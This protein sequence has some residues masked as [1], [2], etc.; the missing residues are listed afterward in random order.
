MHIFPFKIWEKV[1]DIRPIKAS[2]SSFIAINEDSRVSHPEDSRLAALTPQERDRIERLVERKVNYAIAN[3]IN[4]QPFFSIPITRI[5]YVYTY[6]IDTAAT[7]GTYM[8]INPLFF[9]KL[10]VRSVEFVVL[11][12]LLHCMLEHFLRMDNR[13]P[14]QWNIATDHEINLI[15]AEELKFGNPQKDPNLSSVI[16]VIYDEKYENMA[17]EEI[18]NIITSGPR[19]EEPTGPEGGTGP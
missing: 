16:I 3:I 13:D 18:Y 6:R 4:T 7:D 17:A 9:E 5:K 1:L 15:V 12:E 8:L 10:N 19:P 14:R 11:H 2:T